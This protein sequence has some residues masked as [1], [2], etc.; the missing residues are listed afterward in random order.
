[1][2]KQSF[3]NDLLVFDDYFIHIFIPEDFKKKM[4]ELLKKQDIMVLLN[5]VLD[6]K[7]SIRVVITKDKALAAEIKKQTVS[8]FK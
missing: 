3:A 8:N 2:T 6:T 1:M 4:R 5:A 7:S